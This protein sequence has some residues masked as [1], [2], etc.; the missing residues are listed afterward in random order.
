METTILLVLMVV[1]VVWQQFKLH[2]ASHQTKAMF[3][4]LEAMIE[5]RV[6]ITK[7]DRGV[8]F[9]IIGGKNA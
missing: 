9:E 4:M 2:Q 6:K 1:I 8:V 5:D 7:T 3:L